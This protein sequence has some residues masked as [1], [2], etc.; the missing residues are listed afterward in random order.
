MINDE[1]QIATF[2]WRSLVDVKITKLS[3]KTSPMRT[4]KGIV[5]ER[6]SRQECILTSNQETLLTILL[7]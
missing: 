1:R 7:P 4:E 5:K 2:L 3:T 6:Y